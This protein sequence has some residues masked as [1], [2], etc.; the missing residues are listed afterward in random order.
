MRKVLQRDGT[1]AGRK[2]R[3]VKVRERKRGKPLA[4]QCTRD[5]KVLPASRAPEDNYSGELWGRVPTSPADAIV[6]NRRDS[7][8]T[9]VRRMRLLVVTTEP[10]TETDN[11]TRK[12]PLP[13][14]NCEDVSDGLTGVSDTADHHCRVRGNSPRAER[15]LRDRPRPTC[16]CDRSQS[17][18]TPDSDCQY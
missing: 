6:T 16:C 2:T 4:R 5:E 7:P 1:E 8:G 15:W 9:T 11:R 18:T 3:F 13:M 12:P 17:R 14:K 10:S